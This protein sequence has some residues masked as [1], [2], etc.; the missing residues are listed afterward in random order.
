M[1]GLACKCQISLLLAFLPQ[2]QNGGGTA[3]LAGGCMALVGDRLRHQQ[4][5]TGPVV[6]GAMQP[7]RVLERPVAWPAC[8]SRMSKK[9]LKAGHRQKTKGKRSSWGI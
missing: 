2:W 4:W 7:G 3:V 9:S 6:V 8:G 1:T 5:V